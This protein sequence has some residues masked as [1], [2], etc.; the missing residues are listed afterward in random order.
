MNKYHL[1][2]LLLHGGEYSK[3]WSFSNSAINSIWSQSPSW[4][5]GFQSCLTKTLCPMIYNYHFPLYPP[6]L[7]IAV[8]FFPSVRPAFLY[9]TCK[10]D[11]V[12]LPILHTSALWWICFAYI[13]L[14]LIAW[15][16][17]ASLISFTSSQPDLTEFCLWSL[18]TSFFS[19]VAWL[20]KIY[21]P[22]SVHD[23]LK[24]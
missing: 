16:F 21:L 14:E 4:V 24:R 13:F 5:V 1:T 18:Q 9:A 8:L 23:D 12:S 6:V 11:H 15:L 10:W 19:S 3:A 20:P 22:L 7:L 17:K 2:D